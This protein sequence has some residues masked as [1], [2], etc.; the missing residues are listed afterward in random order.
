MKL[1]TGYEVEYPADEFI[2]CEGNIEY[3]WHLSIKSAIKTKNKSDLIIWN[4]K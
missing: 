2:H 3:W 4:S 1:V